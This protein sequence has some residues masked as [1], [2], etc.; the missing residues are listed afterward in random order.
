MTGGT[1]VSRGA[2]HFL[3]VTAHRPDVGMIEPGPVGTCSTG[4]EGE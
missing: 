3:L 1:L 4:A 2:S